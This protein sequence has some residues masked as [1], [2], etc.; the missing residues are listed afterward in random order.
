MKW[1]A[2]AA[3]VVIVLSLHLA[4][5]AEVE[6][7]HRRVTGDTTPL[8]GVEG[9]ETATFAAGCFWHVEEAFRLVEGVKATSVG[10]T[11]G[12]TEEPTYQEVCTGTTGHAE[13][14]EVVYDPELVS[15]EELLAL[16]WKVHNP[17]QKD[18]Q[19]PDIGHQYR[20]AI[21]CHTPEQEKAARASMKALDESGR[22]R[23]PIVTEIVKAGTFWRAE[24]YHQQYFLKHGLSHCPR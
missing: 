14:V 5:Q 2:L 10:Y 19:G 17:T 4:G 24:E 12:H 16:F 23:Q 6:T 13:A 20:S 3:L 15:Y 22:Y 8:R 11:G 18:R 21:F 7:A 1:A 9:M